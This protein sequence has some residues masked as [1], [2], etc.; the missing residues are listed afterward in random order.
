MQYTPHLARFYALRAARLD[1]EARAVL[2]DAAA[3]LWRRARGL[4]E[5]G[6]QYLERG[7]R[8]AELMRVAREHGVAPS[9]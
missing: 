6:P 7:W 3:T 8:T 9:A 5:Y 2:R 4:A 1:E